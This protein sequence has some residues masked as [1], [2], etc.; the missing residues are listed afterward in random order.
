MWD[1]HRK[2]KS[3]QLTVCKQR[4]EPPTRVRYSSRFRTERKKRFLQNQ[5]YKWRKLDVYWWVILG[6]LQ[7]CNA[8]FSDYFSRCGRRVWS[9]WPWTLGI[10]KKVKDYHP[11]YSSPYWPLRSLSKPQPQ[12]GGYRYM[13]RSV[14]GMI[15]RSWW[16]PCGVSQQNQHVGK[17]MFYVFLCLFFQYN[18]QIIK[19]L[20]SSPEQMNH[21]QIWAHGYDS[22]PHVCDF[23]YLR[24][25]GRS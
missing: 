14:K 15:K 23:N 9:S 22:M 3:T 7:H 11:R 10:Q 21:S 1:R 19:H 8:L 20:L 16:H 17:H 5:H 25:R 18:I 12:P 4:G 24:G 13:H 2:E 6:W